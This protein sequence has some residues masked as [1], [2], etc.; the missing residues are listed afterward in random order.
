[1]S[2]NQEAHTKNS[3]VLTFR[4][5]ISYEEKVKPTPLIAINR[6][7]PTQQSPVEATEQ[8]PDPTF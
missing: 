1:M 7:Q 4:Q 8:H 5:L 6:P 3:L 2:L